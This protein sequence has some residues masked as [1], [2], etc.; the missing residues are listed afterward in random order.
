MQE[1]RLQTPRGD[2]LIRPTREAD[3][4]PYRDLRL[5]GLR[6]A[7]TSFGM[8]ADTTAQRT[9]EQW[10]DVMRGGAGA[11]NEVIYVAEVGGQLVGMTVF[12]RDDLPKVRHQGHLYSVYVRADWRGFGILDALFGACLDWAKLRGVRIVKLSVTATNTAA[13]RAYSRMG[14]SV[15]G[16]DPEVILWDGTYYDELLM[17]RRLEGEDR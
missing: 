11:G 5:E 16:I 10:R 7:P 14:F 13:I 8:D 17:Q 1:R 12:R 3:A 15:Y 4:E 6:M 2:I 9:P